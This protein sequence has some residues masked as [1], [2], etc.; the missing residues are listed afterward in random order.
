RARKHVRQSLTAPTE[1]A[2]SQA[3][4]IRD[5]LAVNVQ[6]ENSMLTLKGAFEARVRSALEGKRWST[7][8]ANCRRWLGDEPFSIRAATEGSYIASSLL[9]SSETSLE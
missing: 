4:W 7:A 9:W 1:N 3:F 8:I 6:I 2:L 5:E